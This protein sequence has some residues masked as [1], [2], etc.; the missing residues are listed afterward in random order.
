MHHSLY[1]P[2]LA[3]FNFFLFPKLKIYHCKVKIWRCGGYYK[4]YKGLK[5]IRR[6]TRDQRILQEIWRCEGYYKKDDGV[7]L[8]HICAIRS[9]F[10][11]IPFGMSHLSPTPSYRFNNITNIL[12]QVWL[13]HKITHESWLTKE[14]KPTFAPYQ[15]RSFNGAPTH[16][17]LTGIIVLNARK[18]I[19]KK[20][21][22]SFIVHFCLSKYSLILDTFWI[23]IVNRRK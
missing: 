14:T 18:T 19:L 8:H 3:P 4:K 11:L 16:G 10:G 13:W 20:I 2:H 21:N 1:T 5:N 23:C 22:V 7:S 6:N 15:K 17:K 9:T 12:L